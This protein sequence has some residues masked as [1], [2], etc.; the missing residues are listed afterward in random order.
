[1]EVKRVSFVLNGKLNQTSARPYR[2]FQVVVHSVPVSPGLKAFTYL[3]YLAT[4][5]NGDLP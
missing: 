1:M 5:W 2:S 4:L 3:H